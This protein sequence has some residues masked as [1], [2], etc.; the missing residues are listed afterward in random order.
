MLFGRHSIILFQV[1]I[2]R[3]VDEKQKGNSNAGVSCPQCGADYIIKFPDSPTVMRLLDTIDKLVGRLC[4]VIAG[5]VCV[6]SLYW[7]C[8]TYGAITVMQV[9]KGCSGRIFMGL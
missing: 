4:P 9:V 5:G 7:T 1:C 3:W 8:V 2:Q 6:G